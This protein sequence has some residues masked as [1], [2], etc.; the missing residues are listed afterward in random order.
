MCLS[1]GSGNVGCFS[2]FNPSFSNCSVV[3]CVPSLNL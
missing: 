2:P 3:E 1:D